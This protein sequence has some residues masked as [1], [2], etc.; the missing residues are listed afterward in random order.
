MLRR[1]VEREG[2]NRKGEETKKEGESGKR[3]LGEE[4][5]RG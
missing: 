3:E 1:K 2:E 5:A 4:G